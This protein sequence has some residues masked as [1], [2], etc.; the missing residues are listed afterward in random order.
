MPPLRP[1]LAGLAGFDGFAS[2]TPP[3]RDVCARS[4]VR[5]R[6][7]KPAK[8]TET[9]RRH[10]PT[11]NITYPVRHLQTTTSRGSSTA[12]VLLDELRQ[13]LGLLLDTLLDGFLQPCSMG[14]NG[15]RT[16]FGAPGPCRG[17]F[18][19][20]FMGMGP[21]KGPHTPI[22]GTAPFIFGEILLGPL[23]QSCLTGPHL[24]GLF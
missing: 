12:G 14:P 2:R 1:R 5:L 16:L 20:M 19:F 4:A 13:G 8:L 22:W 23:K 11:T 17:H 9:A 10:P 21:E 18:K 15:R 3:R 7:L 6:N 24:G